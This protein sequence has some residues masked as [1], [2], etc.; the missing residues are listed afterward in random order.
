MPS[1]LVRGMTWV[2]LTTTSSPSI[3]VNSIGNFQ[4]SM[5]NMESTSQRAMASRPFDPP[6]G[7][8]DVDRVLGVEAGQRAEGVGLEP[9]VDAP[10]QLV[11]AVDGLLDLLAR[12]RHRFPFLGGFLGRVSSS[13]LVRR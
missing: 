1:G 3:A 11:V 6:P 7:A 5:P 10:A 13:G 8:V 9:L 4:S 2:H 12:V